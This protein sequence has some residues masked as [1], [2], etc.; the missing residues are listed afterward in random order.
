MIFLLT[1]ILVV[2]FQL[3]AIAF[4]SYL[5]YWLNETFKEDIPNKQAMYM[6]AFLFGC[7]MISFLGVTSGVLIGFLFL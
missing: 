6:I 4:S 5:L 1:K 3:L 7:I 2:C